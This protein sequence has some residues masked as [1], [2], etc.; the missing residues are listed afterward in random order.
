[1]TLINFFCIGFPSF[2]LAL[3][4]NTAR[5][6]GNF[7]ANVLKRALPASAGVLAGSILCMGAAALFGYS[8][9]MLST[10]CLITACAAG[11]Y[12]IWRISVPFTPLRRAVFVFVIAGL[13]VGV[14]GFPGFFSIARLKLIPALLGALFAAVGCLLFAWLTDLLERSPEKTSKLATGF[15]R[16]VRVSVRGRSGGRKV[17][18]TGSSARRAFDRAREKFSRRKADASARAASEANSPGGATSDT[19]RESV[20]AAVGASSGRKKRYRVE[21]ANGGIRVR[22]PKTKRKKDH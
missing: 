8:E 14:I 12:L 4:P 13:A 17:T 21:Q 9:A 22:M 5:V 1:M 16:G 7:L 20:K 15:G 19:R 10:M 6:R 11:V 18:S 3:G 2:V